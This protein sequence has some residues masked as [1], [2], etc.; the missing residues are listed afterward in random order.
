MNYTF[1]NFYFCPVGKRSTL[2]LILVFLNCLG[3]YAIPITNAATSYT[4]LSPPSNLKITTDSS[5]EQGGAS[6]EGEASQAQ[7]V[8]KG[9][10]WHPGHYTFT[11]QGIK[12]AQKTPK[13]LGAENSYNWGDIETAKGKYDFSAIVKD[14]KTLQASKK[15]LVVKIRYKTFGGQA[16]DG[17]CAPQYIHDLGGV[18]IERY[19]D[20]P[21]NAAS[22]KKIAQGKGDAIKRCVAR[23]HMDP[24]KDA[25]VRLMQA[26]GKRFDR[27]PYFEAIVTEETAGSGCIKPT[28][29]ET[30]KC[31]ADYYL[32]LEYLNKKTREAFPHTVV[33]QQANWLSGGGMDDLF[34]DAVNI[35]YGISGPD[36]MPGRHTTSSELYPSHAGK[37]P[38]AMDNQRATLVGK[39]PAQAYDWAVNTLKLNYVFWAPHNTGDWDFETKIISV[40]DKNSWR[41]NTKCPKNI[42]PCV[43]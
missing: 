18:E 2:L 5:Y 14:L 11:S 17:Q 39:S 35:G 33:L 3:L 27:E 24:V 15:R 22:K 30:K 1:T 31:N 25:L 29:A 16:Q 37:I 4:Q 23:A 42:S 10:K 34:A 7:G 21:W 41:I 28:A 40:L 20:T 8:D 12:A 6:D 13:I 32:S 26:L 19:N 38:L 9:T 43:D 36:L